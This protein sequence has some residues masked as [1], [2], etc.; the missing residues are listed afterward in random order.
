MSKI[1]YGNPNDVLCFEETSF[2]TK[3]TKNLTPYQQQFLHLYD[4][5]MITSPTIGKNYSLVFKGKSNGDW[6]F[7]GGFKDFVRV[8]DRASERKYI[9]NLSQGDV[10][11]VL[12]TDIIETPFIIQGSVATIYE[13]KIQEELVSLEEDEYIVGYIKESTPA[14]YNVSFDYFGVNLVG[15]MPNTL[16]GINK[17]VDSESIVGT[18][19]ELGVES[20]SKEEGTYIVSRR[21]YLQ[22]L[23]P[24]EI[25]KLNYGQIYRG[26]VT[27]TTDFGVFVEWNECLTGMIHKTNLN[28]EYKLSDIEPGMVIEFYIKEVIKDKIILTQVLKDSLWDTIKVGMIL[29]G[30][31]KDNKQFGTLVI[32]DE[33]TTGLIHTSE[34]EKI[35]ERPSEGSEIEVK[36]IAVDRM[37]RKIF[38]T[39]PN[40][41]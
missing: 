8:E 39:I 16:A 34:I 12:I 22:S 35:G 14:G 40:K 30:K 33:E 3:K 26:S 2:I 23:I 6:I 29:N 17:L 18:K 27:G 32:L 11:E 41:K 9:E 1:I 38:L 13:T 15:F 24:G 7:D 4:G 28:P 5:S 19:M 25:K 21:K 20:Y 10:M 36:V 37:S 31:V